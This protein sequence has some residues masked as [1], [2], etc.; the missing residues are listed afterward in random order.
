[1]SEGVYGFFKDQLSGRGVYEGTEFSYPILYGLTGAMEPTEELIQGAMCRVKEEKG[2]HF[3]DALWLA[4]QV[5]SA[6]EDHVDHF[7]SDDKFRSYC[8]GLNQSTNAWALLM[9]GDY[10]LI[11]LARLLGD[12]NFKIHTVGRSGQVLKDV[13]IVD[14]GPR[15]TAVVY[16]GQLMIRYALIYA[17]VDAGSSHAITHEI[18]EKAPGVMFV[19]GELG[20]MEKSMIQSMLALGVPLVTLGDDRGLTGMIY[21]RE[22]LEEMVETAWGLPNVRARLVEKA[23]PEVPLEVGPVFGREKIA[24]PVVEVKGSPESF[25]VAI[26]N[27]DIAGDELIVKEESIDDVSIMVELGNPVVDDIVTVGVESTLLRV[28]KYIRGVQVNLV[29]GSVDSL[30]VSGGARE[31][32]FEYEHLLKVIQVELRNKFPEIGPMRISLLLDHAEIEKLSP[33]I[34][35]FKDERKAHVD[36]ATEESVEAFYGCMRCASFSLSHACTVSPDRPSQCGSSPWWV[37]KA[38]ALLAPGNVYYNCTLIEKGELIDPVK[39]EYSG[40]NKATK[41]RTGGR[42]ERIYLHSIFEHPHTACSCFQNVAY[43]IPELDGIALVD[44]KYAGEAPGGWTW[45]R[46]ANNVAGYQNPDGFT[47]F[48]TLYL[49]SPKFFQ[50]DGGYNRVVWM[51]SSLKTIA[52]DSIPEEKRSL[53]ATEKEATTLAELEEFL[54]SSQSFSR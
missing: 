30:Q 16:F 1:M 46:L 20:E 12:R 52:G 42:V 44:R 25:V 40:V 53:V 4:E 39:G 50:A 21:A 22:S 8:L 51:T 14:Y 38:Q 17:R 47:T 49:K 15:E 28:I 18:E 3:L 19:T 33:G 9:G 34:K 54:G 48:A 32:G 23:V 35:S 41:E 7:I 37:L 45:T 5:E 24:D 13:D 2:G 36:G 11:E 43:Y 29:G 26:P 10:K 27:Q 6:Y 31:S